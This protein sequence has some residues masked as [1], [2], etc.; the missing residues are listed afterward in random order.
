MSLFFY[1]LI[2][3]LFRAGLR[4]FYDV[5][6]KGLGNYSETPSTLIVANH[7]RDL[8][9][10]L[11]ASLFHFH[12]DLLRPGK[13]ISFMGSKSL[14]EPGFL[15][16]W[17]NAPEFV[18][19]IL[20]FIPLDRILRGLNA[21]PIGN[22]EFRSI[23][24]HEALRLIAKRDGN[25][26]I[27]EIIT[28]DSMDRVADRLSLETPEMRIKDYLDQKAY[29]RKKIKLQWLRKPYRK[30]L[31]RNTLELVKA[32]LGTFVKLLNEGGILYITPEGQ[33]STNGLLGPLKDSLLILIEETDP[34]ITVTP[35]NIT[36][37]FMTAGKAR[38]FVNVGEEMKDFSG[39]SQKQKKKSI[40]R[41]ILELTTVTMSQLGSNQLVRLVENETLR[42]SEDSLQERVLEKLECLKDEDLFFDE[43]LLD[44][45]KAARRWELF[46]EYC[47]REEILTPESGGKLA[48]DPELGYDSSAS[49][50]LNRDERIGY[51][52][53]PVRYCN[54]E[55]SALS[56]IDLV[57]LPRK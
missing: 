40:R 19:K 45:R 11:L 26:K 21:Y 38:I 17:L 34:T 1:R 30:T 4:P 22:L 5:E 56:Q 23:P 41:S 16:T 33:L 44:T 14:F 18:R 47:L 24:T 52:Q 37:D 46:L 53:D 54:N 20:V 35:T 13:P 55:L 15:G 31:K 57:S 10:I 50:R 49:D 27:R 7:K 9:S 8:D 48:I 3:I 12:R 6:V 25:C 51:K 28:E 42:I 39:L 36:Y 29:P 32:Q 43:R 2:G